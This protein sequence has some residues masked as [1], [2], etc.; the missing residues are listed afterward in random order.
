MWPLTIHIAR[1]NGKAWADM[2][3]V[4]AVG[5]TLTGEKHVLG[6]VETGTENEPVLT[7][8]LQALGDRGLDLSQGLLVSSMGERLAA[9]RAVRLWPIGADA[10]VPVAQARERGALF[11]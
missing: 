1:S 2:T 9:R 3:M 11:I 7:H 5:I 4:V 8:F 10:A 6:F